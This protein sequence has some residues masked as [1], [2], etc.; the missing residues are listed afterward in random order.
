VSIRCRARE[1]IAALRILEVRERPEI[2]DQQ[3]RERQLVTLEILR[4]AGQR[5]RRRS[6]GVSHLEF[7]ADTQSRR[8]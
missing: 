6:T 2:E 4:V 3:S 8:P 5:A 7:L 1:S